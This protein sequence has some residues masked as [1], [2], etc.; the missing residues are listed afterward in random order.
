MMADSGE[1]AVDDFI[2][3][4]QARQ[5]RSRVDEECVVEFS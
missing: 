5:S 2:H 3:V 4:Q 1:T